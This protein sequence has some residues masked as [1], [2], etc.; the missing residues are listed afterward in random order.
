MRS[1]SPEL[2][3]ALQAGERSYDVA[4]RLG[5][6][7][8]SDQVESWSVSRAY[9]TSLPAAVAAPVGSSAA[10]ARIALA[11]DG[12]QTAAQMYSPWAPRG[13]ADVARPGQ[14]AVLGWG[15]AEEALQSL[16]GRVR[17]VSANAA[18]GGAEVTALDG[19]E[20]LRGRASLPPCVAHV[21]YGINAAWVVDYALRR[22]GIYASPP[23][24]PNA[25]YQVFFASMFGS[26]EANL[27][28]R[29]YT[30]GT[31]EWRPEVSPWTCGP[32]GR[33]NTTWACGW[34]PQRRV[35]SQ[36]TTLVVEWWVYKATAQG[37]AR[38]EVDLYFKGAENT[39]A[40]DTIRCWAD[41][42]AGTLGISVNGASYTRTSTA[43]SQAGRYKIVWQI[44]MGSLGTNVRARGWAYPPDGATFGTGWTTVSSPMA[45][46]YLYEIEA[47]STLPM[48]C[49]NVSRVATGSTPAVTTPW[50]RGAVID[51]L[52]NGASYGHWDYG[53][54]AL[55]AAQGTTWWD[56]LKQ[57]ATDT[58]S[59][60]GFD[61]DGVFYFRRYDYIVPGRDDQITPNLTVT[62]RREV[63][64]ITATEEIDAVKNRVEVGAIEFVRSTSTSNVRTGTDVTQIPP[65]ES[66]A[67]AWDFGADRTWVMNTPMVYT[68]NTIPSNVNVF[69]PITTS[70]SL[71]PVECE[72]HYEGEFPIIIYHNRGTNTAYI[73][74]D[75]SLS[76]N[77][78]RMAFATVPQETLRPMTR[79]DAV[80]AARYGSQALELP[81]SQWRQSTWF[82]DAIALR[83]IDW[84]AWPMPV[85][86]P[87]E[88]LPDPRIQI[89]D[90][91]RVQDSTGSM[92]DGLFRVLGY[93]VTGS[94]TQVRMTVT[95]RPLY[96]P[97][98]PVDA[99]LSPDPV[100]DPGAPQFPG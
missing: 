56:L 30:S 61:E 96:R 54:S 63:A 52:R 65:G 36:V 77:S 85:S 79:T 48:E 26:L 60:M 19:A 44:E 6:R 50:Q 47:S 94:G 4:V 78:L 17:A 23:P 31:I 67:V 20:L 43:F 21:D 73:A 28:M 29:T 100:L 42:S 87:V 33:N 62:S 45:Y 80:S 88:I 9:D 68:G 13:T 3:Q 69:K 83:L 38:A 98:R 11:G 8:V 24:R 46:G 86:Q 82:A 12:L 27:G 89:G 99:G 15:L 58:L 40:T 1:G 76:S 66:V 93:S 5:G 64:Q 25:M 22:S 84:T 90:V 70:G 16:R 49:I 32:V 2:Q 53:F 41:P 18:T 55:P 39:V 10:Q 95:V 59:Y 75:T 7:D 81:A 34:A 35:L 97:A 92:V 57:I 37:G 72:L 91:V 51:L 74:T 14:S 71:A